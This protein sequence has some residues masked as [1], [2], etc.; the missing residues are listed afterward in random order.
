[1]KDNGSGIKRDDA[2]SMAMPHTTSKISG[3]QDLSTL[4]TYGF[5][6]EALHSLAAMASVSVTTR[7]EEDNVALTY[8]LSSSGEVSSTKPS[9][10]ERGTTVI[11][12]NLFKHFPVRR[13]FYRNVKRC[14][15]ELK[16]VEEYLLAFGLGHP[17]IRFQLRHNKHTLWQKPCVSNFEE[18]AQNILGP[19]SYLQMAPL[20]Y[21][22][23]DPMVKIQALVPKPKEDVSMLT[24][25]TPERIF[26]LVNKR[27]VVM[28]S[29][30][31]VSTI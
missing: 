9:H 20:N 13:Q 24:R 8:Q 21:Q 10:L 19:D 28:K 30:V 5:R 11:V 12:T 7:T 31:Q 1:M 23:F 16:K 26:V 25:A 2:L 22:C 18:N 15:E 6:G 14:R 29:V 3:F 17:K 4:R 27:P